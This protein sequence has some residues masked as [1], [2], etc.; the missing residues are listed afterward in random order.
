MYKSLTLFQMWEFDTTNSYTVYVWSKNMKMSE[1][2]ENYCFYNI[3]NWIVEN[4]AA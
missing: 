3:I 2:F 4:D 1:E